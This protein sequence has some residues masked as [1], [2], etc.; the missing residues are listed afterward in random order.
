MTEAILCPAAEKVHPVLSLN[1]LDVECRIAGTIRPAAGSPCCG[2]YV[3]CP[4]WRRHKQNDWTIRTAQAQDAQRRR[5][6]RHVLDAERDRIV[7]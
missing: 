2:E 6:Q 7:A 3:D 4:V 5:A 1:D